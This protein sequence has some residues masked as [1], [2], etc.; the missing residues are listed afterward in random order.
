MILVL[1]LRGLRVTCSPSQAQHHP[2]LPEALPPPYIPTGPCP[3]FMS[4]AATS[5]IE[6]STVHSSFSCSGGG[7]SK[8]VGGHTRAVWQR[9]REEVV[10]TLR[11]Y[12]ICSASLDAL[13]SSINLQLTSQW[14]PNCLKSANRSRGP[15]LLQR[16]LTPCLCSPRKAAYCT[17]PYLGWAEGVGWSS[18]SQPRAWIPC[19]T[20]IPGT[21]C[22]G[23][24]AG[25][26]G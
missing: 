9:S 4:K 20:P 10:A 17:H 12:A 8:G 1:S 16:A 23:P 22:G 18:H 3:E 15:F 24:G 6:I 2:Y 25:K 26:Q 13:V 7:W 5:P 11:P 19:S 21:Q 14:G